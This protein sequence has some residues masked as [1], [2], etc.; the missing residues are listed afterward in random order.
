MCGNL[1]DVKAAGVKIVDF[2]G[3]EPL[4]YEGLPE[5]LACAKKTGLRTT[6]TTNCIL[7]PDRAAEIAGLVD[8]LQFSL[9]A[10]TA[11]EHDSVKGVTSF[12]SVM[13]SIETARSL[14]ER[15]TFIQTVTE[16]NLKS[17]P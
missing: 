7:Y 12:D 11:E 14:G 9:D 3:G 5:V 1:T 2:T 16:K 13:E 4:L 8:I 6:V 15:P 10:A 17:V